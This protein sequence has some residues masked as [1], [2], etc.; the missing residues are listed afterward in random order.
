MVELSPLVC[1]DRREHRAVEQL[2]ACLAHNQKVGGS[3]PP[4]TTMNI[5]RRIRIDRSTIDE[6]SHL[7]CV[8]KVSKDTM[9]VTYLDNQGLER[10]ARL[11]D[12]LVRF[13]SGIWQR[14]GKEAND[15]IIAYPNSILGG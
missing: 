14:V 7:E 11:G 1:E 4:C 15:R 13:A 10:E 2:V 12:Y 5:T 9:T 8:V 3:I 6:V